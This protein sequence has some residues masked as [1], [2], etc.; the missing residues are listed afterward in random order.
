M[1]RESF[2]QNLKSI[3]KALIESDFFKEAN[4]SKF[5][6]QIKANVLVA[7]MQSA[8]NA[9]I[10]LEEITIKNNDSKLQAEKLRAELEMGLSNFLNEAK[11]KQGEALKSLVQSKAMAR[12]VGDNAAINRANG[13]V[14]FLNVVGNAS[15]SAAVDKHSA[16]VINTI[17]Q[18]D[19]S[20]LTEFDP[21]IAKLLSEVQG[22]MQNK[23][24]PLYIFAP[25]LE[26]TLNESVEIMGFTIYTKTRFC[27]DNKVMITD[28]KNYLFKSDK[29][30]E[31]VVSF[32]AA[33]ENGV[34]EYKDSLKIKVI[35][36]EVDT[37]KQ[38]I[39]KF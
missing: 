14:G 2:V 39:Q 10:S 33:G 26:L 12:S 15:E 11:Y 17:E 7:F 19:I 21:A 25:K 5:E 35:Q 23:I 28:A 31:F 38:I 22:L 27:V 37:Q 8:V 9:S 6:Q 29:A 24:K 20:D 4:N 16:N 1:F 36:G 3:E 13:Y 18:I 34:F 32:E 30:G